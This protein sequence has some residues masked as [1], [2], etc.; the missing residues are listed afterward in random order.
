MNHRCVKKVFHL[1]Y[2]FTFFS[3]FFDL[4]A[5]IAFT[6]INNLDRPVNKNE[7]D[8][9]PTNGLVW[10]RTGIIESLY[11]N[12]NENSATVKLIRDL[13][14]L[15][16]DEVTFD[17][18]TLNRKP[19]KHFKPSTIGKLQRIIRLFIKSSI[20]SAKVEKTKK[21]LIQLIY[22]DID[23]K[24]LAKASQ[25]KIA[26]Q[27][28][29]LDKL[30][31]DIQ[32]LKNNNVQIVEKQKTIKN[33]LRSVTSKLTAAIKQKDDAKIKAL[34]EQKKAIDERLAK[35]NQALEDNRN[36][37]KKI[38]SG[39]DFKKLTQ[40]IHNE[41]LTEKALENL[42]DI[43]L[44]SVQECLAADSYYLP[45]TPIQILL[46]FLWKKVDTKKEFIDYYANIPEILADSSWL[47]QSEELAKWAGESF[48]EQ[49]YAN[50]VTTV[51]SFSNDEELINYLMNSYELTIFSSVA[52]K[53]WDPV[54]PPIISSI[55]ESEF[56]KNGT[57]Y[58][59]SNCS[60]T[61]IRNFINILIKKF[62][63][64]A[65]NISIL[66]DTAE[67]NDFT[68]KPELITFYNTSNSLAGLVLRKVHNAF[69]QVVS[70]LGK[71]ILYLEPNELDGVCEIRAT[72]SNV[73]KV[74]NYIL[75]N[76]D[77]DFK[78]M[79]KSKQLTTLCEKVTRPD[80]E[81]K[82]ESEDADVDAQ[83]LGLKID[84]LINGKKLFEWEF[85]EHHTVIY[86]AE[87]KK[88]N[89][90]ANLVQ[91]L[92]KRIQS[93]PKNSLIMLNILASFIR[94]IEV[95]L[96]EP[97]AGTIPF[98]YL[99][100]LI[101]AM[102]TNNSDLK[103]KIL[104]SV[105]RI[106]NVL[107]TDTLNIYMTK[108]MDTF[109]Q[110]DPYYIQ[111][112]LING[113]VN[114]SL[115]FETLMKNYVKQIMANPQDSYGLV[116]TIVTSKQQE[117]EPYIIPLIEKM[118]HASITSGPWDA[119]DPQN[120]TVYQSLLSILVNSVESLYPLLEKRVDDLSIEQ[121]NML[122]AEAFRINDLKLKG[123][124]ERAFAK[125]ADDTTITNNWLG[126]IIQPESKFRD[127]APGLIN[128][129]QDPNLQNQYR[130]YYRDLTPPT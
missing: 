5:E 108:V 111:T 99:Y 33:E 35:E 10:W 120:D 112:A 17:V 46:A 62:K 126:F 129:L 7:T 30:K 83:D 94:P 34:E 9:R 44:A 52:H 8:Y 23:F 4:H 1:A 3:N 26:S 88:V 13:F 115:F 80:F 123:F 47:D 79:T 66:Q 128:K 36:K 77:P 42:V 56:R 92:S 53:V 127:L 20:D 29:D 76:N 15:Q 122:L 38:E 50:F 22:E 105:A 81:L 43:I 93:N 19:A 64:I 48:S 113:I 98:S 16:R 28:Q 6:D 97:L 106:N 12:G 60:E 73:L 86:D 40:I 96:L 49:D 68:L 70:D 39:E 119:N 89:K 25:I 78:A 21:E 100:Y 104:E 82:W 114:K 37:I 61:A 75:F 121:I 14:Y 27:T 107:N 124:I 109:P 72:L 59:F 130:E 91:A 69:N 125:P 24:N 90:F 85:M 102:N 57:I 11:R 65:L 110:D 2:L 103:L 71:D 63:A 116:M 101:N 118:E 54:L 74:L 58:T 87:K 31:K 55:G 41:L 117:A 45:T 32:Q 67:K 18:T 84:F 51:N 95:N